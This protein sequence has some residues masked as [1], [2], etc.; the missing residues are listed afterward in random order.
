MRKA[1]SFALVAGLLTAC[2]QAGSPGFQLSNDFN[3]IFSTRPQIATHGLF[4]IK[5]K[6]KPLLATAAQSEGGAKKVDPKAAEALMAEQD[7][8]LKDL[9][10]LSP[11]IKLLYRYR[12]VM[13]GLAVVAPME[14]QKKIQ[15]LAN[16]VYVESSGQFARPI[17]VNEDQPAGAVA[18]LL[19]RNSVRFIG[20][21][22]AH[23]M[24]IRGQG[25]KV[26]IIDTGIDYTHAM[27]GGAGTEDAYKS[28]D[29]KAASPFFPS[30]KV[31]GGIDLVGTEYDAASAD[32]MKRLPVP[33]AN[34]IDEGGHGSHVAGTVAGHGD[35]SNTYDGVAPDAAL[36]AIK[37]FGKDGSTS[38]AIVIAALEYAADPNQDLNASDRLDVVNLSLGGGYGEGH[39]LYAEAIENL[40]SGGTSVVCSAGN[41]GDEAYIVGSPSVSEAAL[42]VAASVDDMDQN[43]KFR[44]VKFQTSTQGE[45]LVEAIEAAIAKPIEEAGDV[46]GALVYAGLADKDF[47]DE[48]KAQINGKVAFIDRGAVSFADKIRRAVEAGAIGVVVANNQSGEPIQMGGDGKF[49]VPAIMV[50]MEV[51]QKLK[52]AQTQGEVTIE[53]KTDQRIE[54]PELIDTIA[55]FSSKGPRSMDAL[56]KPEISAP[57]S[58]IISAKMG[59][60][61]AGVALSG[62]S[63]AAPHMAGV[64][65]LMKQ[66]HPE[67]NA[68]ELKAAVMAT[69]K[70]LV[71]AEKKT[72]PISRQG[73][74]RV[75]VLKALEAQ[76]VSL[77]SAVSL[78]EVAVEGRK[79]MLKTVEVH[80]ISKNALTLALVFEGHPALTLATSDTVTLA[81]GEKKT[82]ALRFTV[83]MAGLPD[84]SLELDGLIQLTSGQA[85]IARI[86]VLAVANK[87]SQV[88]AETLFVHSTS[89]VDSQ[90]AIVDLALRNRGL[91]AGEAYPF[92]WIGRDGRKQ[93]PTADSFRSRA[94]D[95]AES[96]YRVI[97]RNGKP[98]L[99][100]AVKLYEPMTTWDN[101]EVSV[102]ID[103]N[104][105]GQADQE[106]VGIKQDHLQGLTDKTFASVLLDAPMAMQIRKRFELDTRA[107]K[108]DLKEDYTPAVLALEP[109]L[110]PQH[111]TVAIVEAPVE[112]LKQKASGRL[113]VRIATSYQEFTAVEPDDFLSKNPKKWT[114]LNVGVGGAAYGDLP[115]KVLVGASRTER[116]S[117]T[118]G[119]GSEKLWMLYPSNGTLVGGLNHDQQSEVVTPRYEGADGLLA[120]Q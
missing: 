115:E 47:S 39:H 93:D 20:A 42:S 13:N 25:L 112:N 29:P 75:Q 17:E 82:L 108:A 8:V 72:Y 21:D 51:G 70:T 24:G 1:L 114:T 78:G 67:L 56:V 59:G 63:M 88:K 84:A 4:L 90:G 98:V 58:K 7:K 15:S 92:N 28:V 99:Q 57:G 87:V 31:I 50:S 119:A 36:Y 37:V 118:K 101:C 40:S 41:S 120:G 34:P 16:V 96:G 66:T 81:A 97:S 69:A 2:T 117:F 107:Q 27:F 105:D 71:D 33:D 44:A 45:L 38:D 18:N 91:N 12:L 14:L 79:T 89:A 111:S 35:G 109:M 95:L 100:V 54:K 22:Q 48:L 10:Q 86:P 60:G 61:A 62:T 76:V 64:M 32:F 106:L 68:A 103:G 77:P 53:F 73:A 80:N 94:C 83:N 5:L 102:L 26:G 55:S 46:R 19:E 6:E 104:G 65:A 3:G 23:A 9:Q 116:V 110:A 85:E 11:E 30:A 74:G 49:E 43:W 113:S 52:E